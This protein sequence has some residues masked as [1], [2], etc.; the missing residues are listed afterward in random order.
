MCALIFQGEFPAVSSRVV[1]SKTGFSSGEIVAMVILDGTKYFCATRCMS[2]AVTDS[3]NSYDLL[4]DEG[5]P[6]TQ[7]Y[8]D[9]ALAMASGLSIDM[10]KEYLMRS[11]VSF[12]ITVS[13]SVVL[14]FSMASR[15]S[16]LIAAMFSALTR[17][18]LAPI[19]YGSLD[20]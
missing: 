15:I 6:V 13:T 4:I 11:F 7:V 19:R 8:N 5:S 16:F 20:G 17:E 10:A 18:T 3:N 2:V 9:T 14:A 1:Y 12:S